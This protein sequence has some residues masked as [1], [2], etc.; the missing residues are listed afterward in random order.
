MEETELKEKVRKK[1]RHSK[2][3]L[4]R[5]VGSI[6]KEEKWQRRK[7]GKMSRKDVRGEGKIEKTR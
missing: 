7:K 1:R 4:W 5:K 2:R 6:V 3:K